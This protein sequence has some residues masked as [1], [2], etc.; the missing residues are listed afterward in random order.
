MK[1]KAYTDVFSRALAE[2]LLDFKVAVE[3]RDKVKADFQYAILLGLIGGATLSGGINKG[4]GE[5]L[6]E[7][8]KET[9]QALRDAFGEAPS[10]S[11]P[12]LKH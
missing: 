3:S 11:F 5:K 6:L 9:E 10:I 1:D 7:T 8:L 12:L 2:F 4:T